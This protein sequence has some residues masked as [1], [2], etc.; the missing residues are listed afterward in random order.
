M[1]PSPLPHV[2]GGGR[3]LVSQCCSVGGALPLPALRCVR[4]RL[5][6]GPRAR[7]G[8]S[9]KRA[10]SPRGGEPGGPPPCPPGRR[11]VALSLCL[12]VPRPLQGG[13]GHVSPPVLGAVLSPAESRPSIRE[14]GRKSVAPR[15]PGARPLLT[16]YSPASTRCW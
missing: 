7:G 5:Q 14:V 9:R 8:R 3:G 11:G 10:K 6:R 2:P 12:R 4:H 16:R 15:R 13:E 1:G